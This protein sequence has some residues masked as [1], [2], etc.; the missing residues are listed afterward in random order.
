MK[1]KITSRTESL[2]KEFDAL[3][4]E[5]DVSQLVA[6]ASAN[7][8]EEWVSLRRQWPSAEQ[9]RA[10]AVAFSDDELDFMVGKVR[11]FKSILESFRAA[12]PPL[13]ELRPPQP[14]AAA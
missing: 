9:V 7:A 11:R 12:A 14:R 4:R 3:A 10:G 13:T 5:I 6:G 8:R 2:V 1:Y